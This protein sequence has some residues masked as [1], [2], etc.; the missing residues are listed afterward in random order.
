MPDAIK[1]RLP[2]LLTDPDPDVRLLACELVR[3]VMGVGAT[4]LLC[5]LIEHDRDANVCAAAIDVLAEVGAPEALSA[6]EACAARFPGQPFL[7][8]SIKV[9]T[10]RISAKP[11]DRRD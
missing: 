8:F 9:A 6:L 1:P 5:D 7:T 10:A 4:R 3:G 11:A 2:E